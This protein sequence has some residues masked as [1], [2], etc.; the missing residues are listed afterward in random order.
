MECA[1]ICRAISVQFSQPQE[2]W[3]VILTAIPTLRIYIIISVN[4]LGSEANPWKTK[5]ANCPDERQKAVRKPVSLIWQLISAG[6]FFHFALNDFILFLFLLWTWSFMECAVEVL[7]L[8]YVTN[9]HS[10]YLFFL[11][12]KYLNY[13]KMQIPLKCFCNEFMDKTV[14]NMKCYISNSVTWFHIWTFKY[15]IND[16]CRKV[17]IARV[18]YKVDVS[19][20]HG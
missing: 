13:H 19:Q 3:T 7:S 16:H 17:S 14:Y 4:K 6:N 2:V 5:P 12:S 1:N 20:N 9:K 8:G 15:G 18:M 11:Y 10:H